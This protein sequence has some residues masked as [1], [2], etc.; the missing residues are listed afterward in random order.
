MRGKIVRLS[1]ANKI[2]EELRRQGK[3]II[4]ADGLFDIL[5]AVHL[6]HLE[7]ARKSGDCLIIGLHTDDS[8]RCPGSAG[9]VHATE[10]ERAEVLSGLCCVDYVVLV[11][12]SNLVSVIDTLKPHLYIKSCD[13]MPDNTAIC[14][15]GLIPARLAATRLPNKPLLDIAGKPM[16]Q[17]VYQHAME[18][19]LLNEVIVATPDQEIFDSVVSFGGKA[20][21]TSA[22][23]RSGTD[24]LAEAAGK[25]TADIIVNIQGDE[26]LLDPYAI[27]LL[28]Q[29]MLR[30]VD[31]PMASL[32]CPITDL[33]E[34]DNP[35]VV[36]VVT[37]NE[38]NALYFSRSRIPY[39]RDNSETR[40]M[41]HI[42][43]YAYTR[44]FL[45]IFADMEPTSLEKSESLEQLRALENGYRIKMV[46]TTFSPTSVDTPDD[47][48]HVRNILENKA[49]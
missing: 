21:M 47:L 28:A 25:I 43:I 31:L 36:K 26:P 15:A 8:N 4:F 16:I 46:E 11:D 18:S 14:I 39:T 23:H 3:K 30:D 6:R 9:H 10:F 38:N 12:A 1:V 20:I 33:A 29:A 7:D 17:W 2:A 37:N 42:G 40:I 49:I 45:L 44:Q 13:A 19:E 27:D 24:R 35:S 32:M 22:A 41:K 48:E 5:D 34:A